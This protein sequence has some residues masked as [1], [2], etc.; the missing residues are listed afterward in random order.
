MPPSSPA[1]SRS[2][3]K[4]SAVDLRRCLGLRA[5]IGHADVAP[6]ERR[7]DREPERLDPGEGLGQDRIRPRGIDRLA[8]GPEDIGGDG[9]DRH[10]RMHAVAAPD[11]PDHVEARQA[12]HLDVDQGDV[13]AFAV[14]QVD[15]RDAIGRDLHLGP[16]FR[17]ASGRS[18][19]AGWACP[20]PEGP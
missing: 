8:V 16:P 20:R 6:V 15:G 5:K 10:R 1:M 7:A 12:R 17:Q 2:L 11:R 19:I 14:E 13:E 4:V 9:H 3:K 18:A